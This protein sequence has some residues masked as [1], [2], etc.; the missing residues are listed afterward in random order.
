MSNDMVVVPINV[1]NAHCAHSAR[2]WFNKPSTRKMG[3][4][5]G[6]K[7]DF[8]SVTPILKLAIHTAM[9]HHMAM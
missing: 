6:L 8:H 9:V 4:N 2:P 1:E 3:L 5:G 7:N